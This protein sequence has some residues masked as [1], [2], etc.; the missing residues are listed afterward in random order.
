MK[1]MK[2]S[3]NLVGGSNHNVSYGT[4]GNNATTSHAS[5]NENRKTNSNPKK[6][7]SDRTGKESNDVEYTSFRN[8]TIDTIEKTD[9]IS[10]SERENLT[11][12]KVK[13]SQ[14]KC[15]N[16]QNLAMILN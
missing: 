5:V 1:G 13:K 8:E 4:T 15:L 11:K 12:V 16:F 3:L 14:E 7:K 2:I 6:R 9:P 10:I